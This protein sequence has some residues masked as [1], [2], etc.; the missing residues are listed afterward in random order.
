ML[1]KEQL[2]ESD[3]S[4]TL[5]QYCAQNGLQM[6]V[7]A[8]LNRGVNPNGTCPA[9]LRSPSLLALYGGHAA[10]L[11]SFLSRGPNFVNLRDPT[12][13]R[14]KTLSSFLN[15]ARADTSTVGRDYKAC[16]DLLLKHLPHLKIDINAVDL[17]GNT[18]LHYVAKISDDHALHTLLK[19]GADIGIKLFLGNYH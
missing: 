7:I 17:K 9:E 19:H 10:V 16:L 2:E 4:L 13:L 8:L 12:G 15:F 11:E 6:P 14:G 18:A 5:L 3:G 1:P